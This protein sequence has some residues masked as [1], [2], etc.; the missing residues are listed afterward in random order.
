MNRFVKPVALHNTAESHCF[1]SILF[2][3]PMAVILLARA[4]ALLK[5]HMTVYSLA[6]PSNTE[7]PWTVRNSY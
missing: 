3:T 4:A 6:F 7:I 1:Q 2:T 5:D